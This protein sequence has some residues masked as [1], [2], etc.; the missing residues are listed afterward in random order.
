MLQ[1]RKAF[2][3]VS[4][5]ALKMLHG[6]QCMKCCFKVIKNVSVMNGEDRKEENEVLL[7]R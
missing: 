2:Q 4:L 1:L 3:F 5:F 7:C 6:R